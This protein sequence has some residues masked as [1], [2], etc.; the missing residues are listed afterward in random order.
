MV[1]GLCEMADQ[2]PL[3]VLR[4]D[5]IVLIVGVL[6]AAAGVLACAVFLLRSRQRDWPLLYFG[7]LSAMYGVRL[8]ATANTASYLASTGV[9]RWTIWLMTGFIP[10]PAALFFVEIIAPAWRWKQWLAALLALQGALYMLAH[11]TPSLRRPADVANNLV[12]LIGMPVILVAL[13]G[14]WHKKTRD[15]LWLRVGITA[16]LAFSAYTNAVGLKLIPGTAKIEFV[17]FTVLLACFG[18]VA[19]RRTIAAEE[20]LQVINRELAL[21]QQI[22]A[23]L[24][25]GSVS[26]AGVEL[27]TR[28]LPVSSVAGDFYDF[29]PEPGKGIGALI[30]DVAGHG[31]PAALTA[32]MV[33]IAIHAQQAHAGDPATVLRGMNQTLLGNVGAQYVTAA[34]LY[35]DLQLQELRYSAAGHPPMLV[36]RKS[37]GEVETVEEN[38]LFLGAFADADYTTRTML[39]HPGDRCL[40]YTDGIT[41]APDRAGEEFGVERLREFMATHA[42]LASGP[43]CDALFETIHSWCRRREGTEQHDDLTVILLEIAGPDGAVPA[44]RR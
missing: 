36:W 42:N 43:W 34:Y 23:G 10:I 29:L 40:L 44:G 31:I 26:V 16:E 13:F 37:G 41:E 19:I 18:F 9:L 27:T 7:L 12:V 17:G 14:P 35:F 20:S 5:L 1:L 2:I 22:Q 11:A 38:G 15:L 24:L 6:V 8:L 4:P 21:A 3:S 25:P 33:K 39:L 32:S 28:Y 30:A